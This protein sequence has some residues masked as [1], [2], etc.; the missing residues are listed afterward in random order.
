MIAGIA[1]LIGFQLLGETL[2]RV[3]GV[4][5]PGP[6]IGMAMLFVFILLRPSAME[7]IGPTAHYLLAVLA[8]LFVPASL[9]VMGHLDLFADRWLSVALIIIASVILAL[10][11][12]ALTFLLLEKALNK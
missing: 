9:G 7:T 3:A 1:Y 5:L 12:S 11:S 4:P 8:M 2:A 10:V 6:V